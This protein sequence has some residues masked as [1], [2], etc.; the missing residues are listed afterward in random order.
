[1]T[2][3]FDFSLPEAP[4]RRGGRALKAV[5]FLVS[6]GTL[7]VVL[8]LYLRGPEATSGEPKVARGDATIDP[9][10]IAKAAEELE[11]RTLYREA[12]ETW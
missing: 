2:G 6:I 11:R 9:A 3:S 1:M 5:S 4:P 12:A 10:R 7:A 8:L